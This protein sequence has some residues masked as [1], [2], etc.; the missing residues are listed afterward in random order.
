MNMDETSLTPP[1]TS[2]QTA[3]PDISVVIPTC[4]RPQLLR[5]CLEALA[6]QD[7]DPSAFEIVVVDDGRSDIT[8]AAVAAFIRER[9]GGRTVRYLRPPPGK[10]GPAAAR[11]A[12]W[13]AARGDLIAFTDDDTIP[14]PGWLREG[15]AAMMPWVDAAWGN[16]VVPLPDEPTDSERNTFGLDGAEFVTANC[17]VQRRVLEESGGFDERFTRPW[18]EDSDLYFTLLERDAEIVAAPSAVVIHPARQAPPSDCLRQHRNLFFDA[19]LYKKHPR[20]Y[21]EKI[22]AIPPLPYYIAVVAVFAAVVAFS[23]GHLLAS[24]LF[25]A[26]WVGLTLRLIRRRLHGL[27]SHWRERIGVALTSLVIPPLALFWRLA[28]AWY[29]RV[30]FA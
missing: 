24:S 14:M 8:R 19:L 9:G 11:N 30:A 15:M 4:G 3:T 16:V 7:L 22:A 2:P 25:A 10:R 29:F 18:R 5:R 12:G 1:L 21:R 23:G 27:T 28:G 20:L 13:R 26:T 17:F 6:T